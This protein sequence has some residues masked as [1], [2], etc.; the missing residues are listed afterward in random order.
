MTCKDE[1][2]VATLSLVLD[3][4]TIRH[5]KGEIPNT[6]FEEVVYKKGRYSSRVDGHFT[7]PGKSAN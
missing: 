3:E 4:R 1:V 7:G 5:P 6:E 2:E